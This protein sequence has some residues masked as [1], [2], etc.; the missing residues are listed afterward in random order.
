MFLT[1]L[2]FWLISLVYNRART[3]GLTRLPN[4]LTAC[5]AFWLGD[6][7]CPTCS[8]IEYRF[9]VRLLVAVAWLCPLAPFVSSLVACARPLVRLIRLCIR[10]LFLSTVLW[11]ALPPGP[12]K[13]LFGPSRTCVRPFVLRPLESRSCIKQELRISWAR[14]E[15]Q[16]RLPPCFQCAK[17]RQPSSVSL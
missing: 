11:V 10:P 3:D 6:R 12:S 17:W 13:R 4:W 15:S 9:V 16:D 2:P 1:R 7:M 5:L 8:H 14:A